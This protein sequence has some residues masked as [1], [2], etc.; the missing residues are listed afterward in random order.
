MFSAWDSFMA[1]GD[2]RSETSLIALHCV[3]LESSNDRRKAHSLRIL[4]KMSGK[5]DR[6]NS[7]QAEWKVEP[8]KTCN[9]ADVQ[10]P[11]LVSCCDSNRRAHRLKS[12]AKPK[13]S[14]SRLS[15][16]GTNAVHRSR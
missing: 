13:P 15:L 16:D 6:Q 12:K 8:R 11:A 9:N 10:Q 4:A 7:M 5:S 14:N 2:M 1:H 3:I